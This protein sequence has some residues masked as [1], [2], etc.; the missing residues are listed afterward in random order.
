VS[1]GKRP[2]S[3]GARGSTTRIPSAPGITSGRVTLARS[4]PENEDT[5]RVPGVRGRPSKR[6]DPLSSALPNTPTLPS[7]MTLARATAAPVSSTT[8]PSRTAPSGWGTTTSVVPA[9]RTSMSVDQVGTP[10]LRT[11]TRSDPGVSPLT[12]QVPSGWR[13]S[14][15]AR[16][17]ASSESTCTV[18]RAASSRVAP[19]SRTRTAPG[20]G[21]VTS[22]RR[23]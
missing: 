5:R 3:R 17:W 13:S 11:A 2:T 21:I 16:R 8:E 6:K 15:S 20:E 18:A 9:G 19:S 23:C 4:L 7:Q 14:S 12:S 1:A 10:G 22:R